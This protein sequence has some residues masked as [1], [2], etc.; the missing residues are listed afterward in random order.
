GIVRMYGLREIAT[1]V[2]LLAARDPEPWLW[3]RVAGDALDLA[4]L[5]AGRGDE[6]Q[7]RHAANIAMLAVAQV[8]AVDVACATALARRREGEDKARRL[9]SSLRYDDRSGFRRPVAQMRG[10]ARDAIPSD[11]RTPAL[12]QPWRDGRPVTEQG[13]ARP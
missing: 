6:G 9:R 1:G 11:Y 12:L 10:V 2:G 5:A 4:T 8:A 7:D 13:A 3:G